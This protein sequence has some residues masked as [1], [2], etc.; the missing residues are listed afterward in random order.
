MADFSSL[1]GYTVKDAIARN[2]AKG[3]NQA[4]AYSDYATMVEALNAMDNEQ[5]NIGQNIYIGTVGVPDLWVY[6]IEPVLHDYNHVSDEATVELLKNNGTIQ[7][8]YYKLAMLEGQK[9]DL[10]PVNEQLA[11][12]T[13]AI[14]ANT[15]A[16]SEQNKN[17][18]G[19]TPV[20]DETGK[21]TGY[22]T[23]VGGADTVF[24]FSSGIPLFSSYGFN[25]DYNIIYFN[26]DKFSKVK[27]N[28][29]SRVATSG[30]YPF[31]VSKNTNNKTEGTYMRLGEK[32]GEYE[33]DIS[34][35]K[36]LTIDVGYTSFPKFS[37]FILIE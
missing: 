31:C 35:Y 34:A 17:L 26:I 23:S 2:I 19:F 25:K 1:N 18:G 3:R 12:H 28:C 5:F 27:Y 29:T 15:N 6:S 33:I 4:L 32:T 13:N 21:I 16:I 10:T 37:E 22:K 9:V 7:V 20:I 11:D 36:Y 8:G 14:A 30:V 24:P